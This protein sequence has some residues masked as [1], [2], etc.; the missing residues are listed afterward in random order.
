MNLFSIYEFSMLS[1]RNHKRI[2]SKH[3][4]YVAMWALFLSSELFPEKLTLPQINPLEF[5]WIHSTS[6]WLVFLVDQQFQPYIHIGFPGGSASKESACNARDLSSI[7]SLVRSPGE[8]NGN[9]LRYSGLENSMGSQR[10][11]HN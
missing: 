8:G 9:P 10:V 5:Y 6:S 7:P 1:Q 11:V 4:L 3:K 2:L